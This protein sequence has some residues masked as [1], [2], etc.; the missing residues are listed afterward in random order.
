MI[1]TRNTTLIN[2]VL[3][4]LKSE[5]ERLVNEITQLIY[6]FRGGLTRDEAWQLTVY[7]REQSIEFINERIKAAGELMKK[8]ITAFI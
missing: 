1:S 5:N 8:G 2:Q 4:Q 6:W 7:E 3:S